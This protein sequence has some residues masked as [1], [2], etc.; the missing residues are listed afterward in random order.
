MLTIEVLS[1]EKPVHH[2]EGVE[3]LL[4]TTV[5]QLGIRRGHRPLI[6]QLI[7]GTVVVKKDGA[8]DE[9]LATFGGFVEVFGNTVYVMADSAELAADLDELKIQE[10][11][12]RAENLKKD[13]K[14]A[15]E[16]TSASALLGAS[17]LRMKALHRHQHHRSGK[18]PRHNS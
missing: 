1:P 11:I 6:A 8:A 17:L 16:L 18:G 4:P 7:P 5:G 3:V 13:A 14:D 9:V 15:G 10:A 12:S 2:T